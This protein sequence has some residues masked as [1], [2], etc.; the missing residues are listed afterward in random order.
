MI[1]ST[2]LEH[3]DRTFIN[4]ELIENL[5]SIFDILQSAFCRFLLLIWFYKLV[6]ACA[7]LWLLT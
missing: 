6:D 2:M 4:T 1:V 3:V 7:H 5:Q